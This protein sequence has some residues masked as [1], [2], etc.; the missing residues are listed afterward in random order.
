MATLSSKPVRPWGRHPR[1]LIPTAFPLECPDGGPQLALAEHGWRVLSP[2]RGL[3]AAPPLRPPPSASSTTTPA[4]SSICSTR[5]TSNDAVIGGL[6]MGGLRDVCDPMR[7]APSIRARPDPGRHQDRRRDTPEGV[8][9]PHAAC[10]SSCADEGAVG[11]CGR[12]DSEA[13]RRVHA[14]KPAGTG[15]ARARARSVETP[16][17]AIAGAICALMTRPDSTPRPAHDSLSDA[18]RRRDEDTL[19]PPALCEGDAPCDSPARSWSSM[20]GAGHLSSVEQPDAFNA[21]LAAFL[22][23]RV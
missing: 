23:H 3:T 14:G 1:V 10:C 19:T 15:R 16:A 17:E 2:V 7:H 6:S 11:C 21:A 5:C 8:D 9:R 4:T 12:D 20:P 22:T 18:D 13:P